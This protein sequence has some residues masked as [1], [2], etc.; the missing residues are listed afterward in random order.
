MGGT[1]AM[2]AFAL[3]IGKLKFLA[4]IRKGTAGDWHCVDSGMTE[5]KVGGQKSD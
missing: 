2:G 5:R 1:E 3:H 4:A